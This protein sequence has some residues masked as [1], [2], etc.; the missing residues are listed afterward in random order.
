MNRIK[1]ISKVW[2]VL[3]IPI[4]C[5][6]LLQVSSAYANDNQAFT[7]GSG[8][9]DNPY[10]GHKI[11]SGVYEFYGSDLDLHQLNNTCDFKS[12]DGHD[13]IIERKSQFKGYYD[14]SDSDGKYQIFDIGLECFVNDNTMLVWDHED[15]IRFWYKTD[16]WNWDWNGEDFD[17]WLTVEY[18]DDNGNNHCS[19]QIKYSWTDKTD[20]SDFDCE[21]IYLPNYDNLQNKIHQ[22][23]GEKSTARAI[24]NGKCTVTLDKMKCST[25]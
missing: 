8:T 7:S 23:T 15:N 12:W 25:H 18:W 22:V 1:M 13:E 6:L 11:S 10:H 5:C 16:T 17:I 21:E 9:K 19:Q 14:F 3:M 20:Q 4:L 2:F 24:K